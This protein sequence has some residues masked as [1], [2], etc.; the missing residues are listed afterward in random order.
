MS[1]VLGKQKITDNIAQLKYKEPNSPKIVVLEQELV[2]AEAEN[3]VA[4]AQLTNIVRDVLSRLP[5][6]Y[7]LPYS[8]KKKY[9]C[10]NIAGWLAG[11]LVRS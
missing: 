8:R 7:C 9:S 1:S 6:L 4:E 2:R 11:R 5:T 10:A 3:L